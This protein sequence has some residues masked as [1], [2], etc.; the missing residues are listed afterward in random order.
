MPRRKAFL[1]KK[2]ELQEKKNYIKPESRPPLTSQ[3][4]PFIGKRL[5]VQQREEGPSPEKDPGSGD[6]SSF[7]SPGVTI[8]PLVHRRKGR[9]LP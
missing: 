9:A 2:G 4:M 1:L 5:S 3:S 8:A 6:R 7:L